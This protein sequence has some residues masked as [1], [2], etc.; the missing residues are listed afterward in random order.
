MRTQP[1]IEMNA[2]FR[3]LL[4]L[5]LGS[6]LCY[7]TVALSARS[8]HV[9]QSGDHTLLL[10]MALFA[11][12][13]GLY[14]LAVQAAHRTSE[15]CR[16][17]SIIW[18]GAVLVLRLLTQTGRHRGW[19][20]AYGWCPLVIKEIANSG[21]LDALATCSMTAQFPSPLLGTSYS[22]PQFF[23]YIVT[24]LEYVLWLVCLAR[25]RQ[26]EGSSFVVPQSS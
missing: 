8:L 3:C 23:D 4:W 16:T 10:Q 14:L 11:T 21:H 24:W 12:A 1:E 22:G 5:G 7:L 9:S 15:T 25:H 2:P 18:F 6:W 17:L 20:I 26:R 19:A 13:F